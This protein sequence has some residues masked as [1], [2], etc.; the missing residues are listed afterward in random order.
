MENK[1]ES[2]LPS[3]ETKG[4]S[5]AQSSLLST[6]SLNNYPRKENKRVDFAT[7]QQGSQVPGDSK[8]RLS[9]DRGDL[10]GLRQYPNPKANKEALYGSGNEWLT[11]QRSELH[12]SRQGRQPHL[13]CDDFIELLRGLSVEEDQ[14]V[15]RNPPGYV[16]DG[17]ND[18]HYRI[19]VLDFLYRSKLQF[20]GQRSEDSAEFL[21]KL[22]EMY[23]ALDVNEQDFLMCIPF[24]LGDVALKWFHL[25]MHRWVTFNQFARAWCDRFVDPDYLLYRLQETRSKK[26]SRKTKANLLMKKELI[27]LKKR[28][29][30]LT[31]SYA[32]KIKLNLANSSSQTDFAEAFLVDF[33][34]GELCFNCGEKGHFSRNCRN[35]RRVF[36][37][38]CGKR[39]FY[40]YDCPNCLIDFQYCT[41]CGLVGYSS[42][43]CPECT[44]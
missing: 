37:R 6:G 19:R 42:S 3:K 9:D 4:F 8:F 33:R 21:R 16:K 30:E 17:Y 38:I 35:P 18:R 20:S 13:E 12:R 11:Y 44:Y 41:S 40:K 22:R 43:D 31:H 2:D 1:S 7:L 32:R 27:L 29:N 23:C 26:L 24:L 10:P 39:G 34:T 5:G 15:W 25:N 28:V 36:C 14:G